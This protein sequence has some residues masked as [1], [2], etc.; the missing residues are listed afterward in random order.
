MDN[1]KYKKID[2]IPLTIKEI[3]IKNEKYK[4]YIKI[5]FGC[6]LTINNFY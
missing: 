2:N 5:P 3:I 6:K 4:K 1:E